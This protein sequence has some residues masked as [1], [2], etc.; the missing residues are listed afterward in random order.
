MPTIFGR[1]AGGWDTLTLMTTP[2]ARGLFAKA[3]VQ[4]G[5]GWNAP[6]SLSAAEAV[7]WRWPRRSACPRARQPTSFAA[8]PVEAWSPRMAAS[9]PSSTVG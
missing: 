6:V 4:S 2:A 5:G 7:A 1:S 8:L 3:T 9:T